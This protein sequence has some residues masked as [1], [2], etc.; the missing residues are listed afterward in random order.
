VLAA[1]PVAPR[2]TVAAFRSEGIE[3][4]AAL[5]PE[6]F[7]AVGAW[8]DDFAATTDEEVVELLM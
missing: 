1:V 2:E 6:P 7:G 5:V 3:L 8:Y 4:V